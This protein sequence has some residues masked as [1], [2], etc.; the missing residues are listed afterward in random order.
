MLFRSSPPNVKN[1][2]IVDKIVSLVEKILEFKAQNKTLHCHTERSE[3]SQS[4]IQN[5]DISVFSKPQYDKTLS[6]DISAFSK[7]QYDNG[8]ISLNAQSAGFTKETSALL[9]VAMS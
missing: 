5:R 3:V 8:D 4:K 7:P 1:Q 2:K 9:C 6:R